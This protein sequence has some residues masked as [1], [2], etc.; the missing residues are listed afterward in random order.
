[1]K[2]LIFLI[3]ILFVTRVYAVIKINNDEFR[4]MVDL[5]KI[6]F[7]TNRAELARRIDRYL[8]YQGYTWTRVNHIII[9]DRDALV[10]LDVNRIRKITIK[11]EL[12][13]SRNLLNVYLKIK[14]GDILDE[15]VLKLQL[16]KLYNTGL[17]DA[18]SYMLYPGQRVVLIKVK[19]K[20]RSYLNYSGNISDNFGV[21]PFVEFVSRDFAS[22]ATRFNIGAQMGFWE[23]LNYYKFLMGFGYRLL[24]FDYTYRNGLMFLGEDD[25]KQEKHIFSVSRSWLLSQYSTWGVRT[26]AEHHRF[27]DKQKIDNA[28]VVQG[29]RLA[30]AVFYERSNFRDIILGKKEKSLKIVI[31]EKNFNSDRFLTRIETRIRTYHSPLPYWGLIYKNRIG[32][33]YSSYIPFDEKFPVGGYTLRG[34]YEGEKWSSAVFENSIETELE[35]LIHVLFVS[36]FFD[37]SVIDWDSRAALLISHGFGLSLNTGNFYS[38]VYF[39]IPDFQ[40]LEDGQIHFSLKS[41]F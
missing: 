19:R 17:F 35:L 39:G 33:L 2:R 5:S 31:Q 8:A 28:I 26:A 38:S 20:K 29:L 6:S 24:S 15:T 25:Y 7:T 12:P 11:G 22:P 9:R 16:K 1:M 36:A 14:E 23:K 21:E 18:I 13:M 41:T 34:Y 4:G 37:T 32:Y 27:Y 30:V 40:K 3:L 10:T